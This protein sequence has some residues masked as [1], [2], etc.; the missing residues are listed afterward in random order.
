MKPRVV[1]A[2]SY[3][4]D[5]C[6]RCTAFPKPGET[7]VGKLTTGPGGK[8]SN[9]A[10]ACGRLG[11]PTLF[12]GAVGRDAFAQ[13][14]REFYRKE[15]IPTHFSVKSR[16]PT[17]TAAIFVDSAGRNQILLDLGANLALTRTDVPLAALRGARVVVAQLESHLGTTAWMLREARK[18][19]AVSILNTAPFRADFDPAMLRHVDVVVPNEVEFVELVNRVPV[20]GFIDF[21]EDRLAALSHSDL[22]ALCRAIGVPTVII[23]LGDKGC[24]VSTVDGFTS[25][26]AHKVGVVDTT[27]AGDAFVG[28]LAA[29][30]ASG[31]SIVDAARRG[32]AVGALSVTKRGTAPSMPT[33]RSLAEFLRKARKSR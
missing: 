15:K 11:V 10:V 2:G 8:G 26:P 18:A 29:G 22:H 19:G 28:G 20:A 9:Q 6:W 32:N 25:L 31:E 24:F 21:S 4:Q 7:I 3:V 12:V 23:T 33:A 1:V 27:G 13:A 5:L 14:A 17:G 16:H 30:L